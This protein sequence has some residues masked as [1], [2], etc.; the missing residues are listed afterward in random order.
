MESGL[1]LSARDAFPLA[2]Y[3]LI[4]H[5][6]G[7]KTLLSSKAQLSVLQAHLLLEDFPAKHKKYHPPNSSAD[8]EAVTIP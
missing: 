4:F 7:S 5:L 3:L 1:P 6:H 2:P 8:K